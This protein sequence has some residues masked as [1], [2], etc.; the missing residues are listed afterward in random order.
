MKA[1]QTPFS[2]STSERDCVAIPLTLQIWPPVPQFE[3]PE[4]LGINPGKF[5]MTSK[6]IECQILVALAKLQIQN[7]GPERTRFREI[8]SRSDAKS[9]EI[10]I[11]GFRQLIK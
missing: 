3:H 9:N 10:E 1:Y 2:N 5:L 6:T 11:I 8:S 4:A 7:A